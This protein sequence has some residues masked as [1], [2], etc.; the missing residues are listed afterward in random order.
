MICFQNL[1]DLLSR[2][3]DSLLKQ[4]SKIWFSQKQI[5]KSLIHPSLP[6]KQFD[7]GQLTWILGHDGNNG[8]VHLSVVVLGEALVRA[9]IS[10]AEAADLQLD[11]AVPRV[12]AGVLLAQLNVFALQLEGNLEE[13]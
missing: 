6:P 8:L 9:N 1:N 2:R 5:L 12:H 4:K 7:L 10:G 11:N 13:R 3:F